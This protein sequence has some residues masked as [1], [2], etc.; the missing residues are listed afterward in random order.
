M[1]L[2]K[3][4]GRYSVASWQLFLRNTVENINNYWLEKNQN[5]SPQPQL[6]TG[7]VHVQWLYLKSED[8]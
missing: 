8:K 5:N 4:G 3:G 1:Y 7:T 2:R 6:N